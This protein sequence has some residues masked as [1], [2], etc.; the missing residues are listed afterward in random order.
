MHTT[1][2]QLELDQTAVNCGM[3][4]VIQLRDGRF[5]IL[6]GGSFT[7]G[8]DDRLYRFLV[9][10]STEEPH[11]AAWYFSH[12]HQDHI[13]NFIQFMGKYHNAVTVDQLL[14]AFHP[15]DLSTV[16]GDW[17]SSDPATIKE[18][19]RTLDL[20]CRDVEKVILHTGD[21]LEFGE[22]GIDVVYTYEDLYPTPASFNDYS[23]VLI[24]NV[25][26]Q[27]AL[28]LGDIGKKA[29]PIL[30]TREAILDCEIVQVPHHGID[31]FEALYELYAVL[32]PS[33]AL[34]PTPDYGMIARKAQ[35]ANHFLLHEA[36]ILEH[37][38][39]GYGT[40]ALPL[41]YSVGMATKHQKAL[42][43]ERSPDLDPKLNTDRSCPSPFRYLTPDSK[44]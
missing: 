7:P 42:S 13:G 21:H 37:I 30:K 12:A 5:F 38:C 14:Y 26:R 32:N 41:P 16:T 20:Y 35:R 15:V 19:Y 2:W 18:F 4:Y 33:V 40:T 25:G 22:L 27:K 31:D 6:D 24:T 10:H 9:E 39:S 29:A 17:K 11:I 34:W 36:N 28:W 23:T 8:E 44:P 1:L 3:S 43:L